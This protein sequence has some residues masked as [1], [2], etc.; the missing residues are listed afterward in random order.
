[1][2]SIHQFK[3]MKIEGQKITMVTCYDACFAKILSETD[4]DMLLV[5]DSVAMVYHG[6]DSTIH[7]TPEMM[8]LHT[9]AVARGA[10]NKFIVGDM[11]FL[12]FR[13]G[14]NFALE[15]GASLMRAGAD[16]IKLEKVKGH[17]E[18]IEILIE[19]G[20]PV[21]GHLGLTPQSVHQLGGHKVQAKTSAQA[22]QLLVD[23]KKLE[24]LGCFSLVLECVPRDLAT[25]VSQA[26]SIPT[27]GIGAGGKTDGQV[28]VLH[29]M[30]GANSE[31]HPK[32]LRKYADINSSTASAVKQ[33]IADV[34]EQ[35]FPTEEESYG[36]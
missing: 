34:R 21:M 15:V 1:M 30:L 25:K 22:E 5:G 23:A 31:F 32:F 3:Q 7:A 27:I 24:S 20:I 33:F 26:L 8:R 11:P 16:A 4:I 2:K 14:P 35:K 19:S 12:S 18:T 13:K 29:D 6:Y 10:P 17:E 9:E 36:A 28:L